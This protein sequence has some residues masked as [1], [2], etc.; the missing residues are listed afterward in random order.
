MNSF[1]VLHLS[2]IHIGDTYMD[3]SDIA[4]RIISDLESESIR[5]IRCVIVTGDIFEGRCGENADIISEAVSFFKTIL[6]ELQSN[7]QIT[8]EDI[9]FVPGNHDVMRTE[10]E[11]IRW[12]KYSAFLEGFYGKLPNFYDKTDFS[13][14]KTYDDSRIAFAGFN[15]CG[16]KQ[17]P[18]FDSKLLKDIRKLDDLVFTNCGVEKKAVIDL[19]DSQTNNQQY[20]D[21]GEI[22]PKQILRVKRELSKYD[23]YT[24]R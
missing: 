5:N 14:L 11:S 24:I 19:F 3:S 12:T 17:E 6:K 4:Y 9:L 18:L 15:S 1:R 16:L 2:D 20:V 10:D 7:S 13:L 21:F 23:D 22:T 8:K